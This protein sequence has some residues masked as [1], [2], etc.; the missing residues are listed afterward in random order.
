[1]E[2]VITYPTSITNIRI[3]TTYASIRSNESERERATERERV[4]GDEMG[5]ET[6]YKVISRVKEGN[7]S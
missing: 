7:R 2:I 5:R 1:M 4:R 3:I 6:E